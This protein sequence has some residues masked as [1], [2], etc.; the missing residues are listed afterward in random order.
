MKEKKGECVFYYLDYGFSSFS[1]ICLNNTESGALFFY[2]TEPKKYKHKKLSRK[3]M[4]KILYSTPSEVHSSAKCY[5]RDQI[6]TYV[7][8]R[9]YLLGKLELK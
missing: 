1:N 9:L 2:Y 4:L 8:G 6:L 7:E 5:N 3:F